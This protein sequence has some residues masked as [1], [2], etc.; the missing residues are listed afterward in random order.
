MGI[1]TDLNERGAYVN[2]TTFELEIETIFFSAQIPTSCWEEDSPKCSSK[3]LEW[4]LSQ[5]GVEDWEGREHALFPGG[6]H[7]FELNSLRGGGTISN[8]GRNGFHCLPATHPAQL[9]VITN[10]LRI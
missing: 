4:K 3:Y 1:K 8:L 9:S 5:H 10:L 2:T 6:S 7:I